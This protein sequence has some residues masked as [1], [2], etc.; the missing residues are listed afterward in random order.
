MRNCPNCG[1]KQRRR[2][3]SAQ[4]KRLLPVPYGKYTF[5]V[6]E[7]LFRIARRNEKVVYEIF[8][9]SVYDALRLITA[10]RHGIHE[11]GVT[12]AVHTA[13]S[14]LSNNLHMHVVMPQVGLSERGELVFCTGKRFLPTNRL[15]ALFRDTFLCKLFHAEFRGDLRFFG[16]YEWFRKHKYF[17]R[18][19]TELNNLRWEIYSETVDHSK[20]VEH[21]KYLASKVA[22]GPVRS[23][24][25][26]KYANG[27]V[28][29][30]T[31]EG[32]TVTLPDREF[33]RRYLY[34]LRPPGCRL[35][36]T[37]GFLANASGKFDQINDLLMT[38]ET[39]IVTG[40]NE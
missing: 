16:E 29:I 33:V 23:Q 24:D 11:I 8:F 31:G 25:I 9:R 34:H 15:E 20:V 14:D 36:R 10:Y 39:D 37:V 4:R 3:Y 5:K 12:A 35:V 26:E 2:F 7:Q 13:G 17:C 40:T 22:R 28:R 18:F 6:P 32:K 21:L 38:T 1:G 30:K 19:L 27:R